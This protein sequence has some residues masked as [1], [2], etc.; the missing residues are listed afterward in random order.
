MS[1]W[2]SLL[3]SNQ[4]LARIIE[5]V[6]NPDG[7]AVIFSHDDPDGITSGLIFKR[8]L[9]KKGWTVSWRMP[10]GFLLSNEQFEATMKDCP[11]AKNVFILDKGTLPPYSEFGKKAKVFI[12]DHHPT[13]KPPSDCVYFNPSIERY[14]QCSTSILAHG[15]STLSKTRD[16]FDDF[17]CLLGLKGDWAIEPVKGILADFA[18]PFFTEHGKS[19]KNLF[20]LVHERPTM[21]DAEQ[22]DHYNDRDESLKEIDHPVC[23][24]IAL[25]KL[26]PKIESLKTISTLESFIRLIPE[27]EARNLIKIF[28]FFLDDWRNASKTLDSSTQVLKL[29]DTSVYLFV[30]GKVPLL[31]MIGSIKLF[32]LKKAGNDKFAQIIMVSAVSPEYSHVSV[33]GSGDRVHSGKFCK[34][35]QDTLQGKFPKFKDLISGGGHPR[36]AECT[37]RTNGVTFVTVL[38]HVISQLME[39]VEIDARYQDGKMTKHQKKR[40][41]ELGL[42]YFISE[43]THP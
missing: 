30:G 40:A 11:D 34:S 43:R 13:P 28:Q 9:E 12:V 6:G 21:F 37:I 8:M 38:S 35:L 39:M 26:A 22:R 23:I 15:I 1:Q 41:V 19:F 33:R 32:D 10:P 3:S 24:G 36:A 5:V 27:S 31:P 16:E 20:S 4:G 2:N 29:Q 7:P 25:E 14:T 17:L 18:V 42:E